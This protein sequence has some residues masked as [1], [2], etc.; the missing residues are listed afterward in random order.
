MSAISDLFVKIKKIED[1]LRKV[2]GRL[3]SISVG[4]QIIPNIPGTAAVPAAVEG[5]LISGNA[6]PAWERLAPPVPTTGEKFDLTFNDGD[7]QAHWR[8]K[9]AIGQYRQFV[10]DVDSG[11]FTFITDSDGNP[12]FELENLE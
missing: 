2:T 3:N 8:L 1:E 9:E 6:T 4:T 7:T 12:I 10:Y 5:A 11:T